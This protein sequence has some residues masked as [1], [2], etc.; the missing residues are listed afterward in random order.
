VPHLDPEQLALL[1]LGEPAAEADPTGHLAGCP[2]CRDELSDLRAV[3]QVGRAAGTDPAVAPVSP[4]PRVWDAI[5]AEL[6]TTPAAASPRRTGSQPPPLRGVPV[7][8]PPREGGPATPPVGES[9]GRRV[10]R[11]D[12]RRDRHR[13]FLAAAAACVAGLAI[14]VAATLGVTAL[15]EPRPSSTVVASAT[16]SA[17]GTAA[18]DATGTARV[19]RTGDRVE[20]AVDTRNLPPVDGYYEAWMYVPDTQK[21]QS[22]GAVEPGTVTRFRVP[23]GLE[24]SVWAGIN[25]S[26]EPLDGNPNHSA[27]SVLDGELRR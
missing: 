11:L 13:T 15:T 19:V 5:V 9:T 22:M 6:A 12:A 21:M 7:P 4:P 1:A 27:R 17:V 18:D 14:G 2:P 20:L 24:L 8:T 3:V 25:I 23:D 26:V 16:L 10:V